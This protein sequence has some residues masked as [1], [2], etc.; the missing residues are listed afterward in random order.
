MIQSCVERID[1]RGQLS[2]LQSAVRCA[3]REGSRSGGTGREALDHYQGTVFH[4]S[5]REGT[6][7][8]LSTHYSVSQPRSRGIICSYQGTYLLASPAIP[9]AP[10]L[11]R[12]YLLF[13]GPR[14]MFTYLFSLTNSLKD[15]VNILS[16]KLTDVSREN[17]NKLKKM[18]N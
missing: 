3:R 5:P 11:A 10:S 6:P 16:L 18:F 12:N 4:S 2:W 17:C 9:V 7:S 13:T 1:G 8:E 15:T 14:L